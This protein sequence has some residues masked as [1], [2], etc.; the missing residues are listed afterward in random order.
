MLTPRDDEESFS[1][2]RE[3]ERRERLHRATGYH[4]GRRVLLCGL[5]ALSLFLSVAA[6][7]FRQ[8]TS[9]EAASN[10]LGAG[11]ARITDLDRLIAQDLPAASAVGADKD[12]SPLAGFPINIQLK[13]ADVAGKSAAEV[14][15]LVLSR[16][17]ARVYDDGVKAFDRTGQQSVSRFSGEGVLT[18]LANQ[19]TRKNHDR[20][21][22]ALIVLVI[23]TAFAAGGVLLSAAEE[24]RTR[25]I[26]IGILSAALPGLLLS[27]AAWFAIGAMGGSDS[28]EGAL[29]SLARSVA[30]VP[31]RD[32]AIVTGLGVIVLFAGP[33]VSLVARPFAREADDITEPDLLFDDDDVMDIDDAEFDDDVAA[34]QEQSEEAEARA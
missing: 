6:L 3:R 10:V 4:S 18:T 17:T 19:L 5:F 26:A 30:D 7:A 16:A 29:R 21:T 13:H 34:D 25:L 20:A 9:P 23:V 1:D 14:R 31:L 27:V 33:A 22:L 12:A 28:F 24:G 32:F 8:A 2:A 11:I 15:A